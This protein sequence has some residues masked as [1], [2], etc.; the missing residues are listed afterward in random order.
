[1]IALLLACLAPAAVL[2]QYTTRASVTTSGALT[3]TGNALGLDG[4]EDDNEPG[5]R[6]AIGTF[7][8]TDTS[9][10]DGSFPNGTTNDWRSNRSEATLRLPPGARVIRAELIWGGTFAGEDDDEDVSAFIDDPVLFTTPAG[11]SEV[12]PDPATAITEGEVESDGEC[13]EQCY[14]VRTADV[15]A[16]IAASG[17]GRFAIA[18]VPGTQGDN[19]NND[20]VAGWTLAVLYEDFRQP[21]RNLTLFLGLEPSGGNAAQVSGFCTPPIGLLAGRLA[22]SSIEGDAK[23]TG[24]KL[25][26]G[27]TP[28][29]DNSN[30]V[31]GRRNPLD[32]FFSGQIT[33]D[34]GEL[35]TTGTFGNRNHSPGDAEDGA[36]QGWD[37]TNVDASDQLRNNQQTA[38]AQGTTDGDRYRI[39]ALGL[40]IDVG[41]PRFFTETPKTADRVAAQVGDIITYT[42]QVDNTDGTADAENVVFFDPPPTGTSFV[43]GSFTVDG[44]VRPAAD[45]V[46]GVPLGT[47]ARGASVT[48]TM[49]VQVNSVP[50]GPGAS[51]RS[52]QAQWTFDFVSCA[53]QPSQSS[54]AETNVVTTAVPVADL[55]VT[56]AFTTSPAVAGAP[57]TYTL[58]VSNAGPSPSVATVADSAS[59]PALTAVTWTCTPQSAASI[60]GAASGTGPVASTATL[61]PGGGVVYTV[62]GT[63]PANTP[64]GTLNNTASVSPPTAV[65]DL[66]PANNTANAS[67]PIVT[68]ADVRLTKTGPPSAQRGTDV[69]YSLVVTNNGPSDAVNVLVTD[70]APAGLIVTNFT[71]QCITFPGCALAAGASQT[72]SVVMAIPPDYTG[73]DPI[74]N[75]ANVTAATT[76]PKPA[77]NTARVTTSLDAPVADLAITKTDGVTSVSAGQT[78]TYT[79]TVTNAGPA[80]APSARVVDTFDPAVFTGVTWTCAASGTSSCTATGS[81]TGNIDTLVTLNPGAANAVVFTAQATIVATATG[82]AENTATVATTAGEGDPN[83]TNNS[84][85]DSDT[86]NPL[87]DVSIVQ[88]GPAS[89]VAGSTVTY[90]VVV[91]NS[92]PSVALAIPVSDPV[93]NLAGTENLG[94]IAAFTAPPGTTCETRPFSTPSGV[95]QLQF[96]DIPALAPNATATFTVQVTIPPD[97]ALD[98]IR[99]AGFIDEAAFSQQD[100]DTDDYVSDVITQIVSEADLSVVKTGPASVV[101]GSTASFF[102]R[103]VNNGPS[104]ATDIVVEDPVPA[105]LT[106]V[107]LEGPCAAGFPC[108][109]PSLA[110]GEANGVTTR[111][112]LLIP[113]DYA[114]PPTFVNTAT[115]SS[116]A[117][118]PVPSNNS[119]SV[120][121]LV[122]SA[123]ADL[124]V[125]KTGPSSVAPGGTLEYV[126][127]MTN[128][129]PGIATDVITSDEIPGGTTLVSASISGVPS[130]CTIPDPGTSNLLSCVTPVL[131]V[132]EFVEARVTAQASQDLVIG[133][134]ILNE[135]GV[136]SAMPDLNTA[137]NFAIVQTRVAA[138]TE[139][140]LKIEK[141]DDVDPVLSG[142]NVTY[143]L[144]VTNL[145]PASA[146][147]VS[148]VDTLPAGLSFVSAATTVGT[149]A[150]TTCSLGT[151]APSATAT[152]TIVAAATTTG[153]FQNVATVTAAEVDPAPANNNTSEPTTVATSDQADLAIEK[154]GPDVLQPGDAS[155]YQI[156]VTNR[157]PGMALDVTVND[158][159]PPGLTFLAN[160]GACV[161]AFPCSVELL[162]P[163]Q[164]FMISTTFSVDAGVPTPSTITNTATVGS[165]VTDDPDLSNNTTTSPVTTTIFPAGSADLG[166]RKHDSPDPVVAGTQYSYVLVVGNRGPSVA[167]AVIVVDP[168]PPGVT[169]VSVRSTIGTCSGSTTITC[170]LGT[171]TQ[172]LGA[173]IEI[174]ATVPVDL[175]SPNPMVNTATV[176]S[177]GTP[178]PNPL[179]DSGS[180]PT[181]VVAR[182][183]VQITK[184][185]PA[186]VPPGGAAVYTV[187]VTNAGPST[188]TGVTLDD[189]TP[190]GL[191]PLSVTGACTALPCSLGSIPPA[192]QRVVT[193]TVA[194]PP[195]YSGPVPIVNTA[196]VQATTNDINPANNTATATTALGAPVSDVS[197]VKTGP[198]S[199]RTGQQITYSL[200]VG[201]AGPSIATAV[202]LQD[203]TPAGLTFLTATAPC[204]AGF[205]CALGNLAPGASLSISAT[206]QAPPS[207]GVPQPIVNTA[208]VA[209]APADPFPANNTASVATVLRP[210]RIGCDVDGDG[211]DE[212]VTG[213]GPGGGPH[214]IVFSMAGGVPATLASFFAYDP[215]FDG[216]VYVA[217]G[218]VDG[219]GLADVVTGAGRGGGPHVRVFRVPPG[220]GDV[221]EIAS[222]WAYDPAFGGGVRVA[223]GDV[224][225]DGR[226]DVVTGAGPGGG[227]HVR[228]F[229]VTGGVPTELVSFYAYAPGFP[230]G[231]T[232]ASADVTGDRVAEI[233]T[234]TIRDGGPLRVFQIDGPAAIRELTSFYPY[235]E[236]FPGETRV[237][238]ADIDGD[239]VADVITGAGRFGGP[240]V[241]AFSLAGGRTTELA[242]FYA[243]D[244]V[245]CDLGGSAALR[246]CEGL[247][248]AGADITGDGRAEIIAA[249]DQDAGPVRIFQV[250]PGGIVLYTSFFA[251]GPYWLGP[252]RVGAVLPERNWPAPDVAQP[253]TTFAEHILVRRFERPRSDTDADRLPPARA[254][255]PSA[256]VAGRSRSPPDRGHDI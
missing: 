245:F 150:S 247:F 40:Q 14:Y 24:D 99:M 141:A 130:T 26:F 84:A 39:M 123:H 234:G 54:A 201:N 102:V 25:L 200:T 124:S 49:Q 80:S 90:T 146:T 55:S 1:V 131:P 125:E 33:D 114:G 28:A 95:T 101:A 44:A 226:A 213:V 241:R 30:R 63:L 228:A 227:P 168:L 85:T 231:V 74:V 193:V 172:G 116:A 160:T 229:S 178:D 224:N 254:D 187:T 109:I 37:I 83:E 6:G 58:T 3:F 70:P 45:P 23:L 105:G 69:T 249:N 107:A 36:R 77:N 139:A 9:Q 251:Y 100:P 205:P 230:G 133:A 145:G 235:F 13:D 11:T 171:L 87:A 184:S 153:L 118:D 250:V 43:A 188:A 111:V 248:V 143:T 126:I 196:T 61:P 19:D 203:P 192:G 225:G 207:L 127:R 29:L 93:L 72:L 194:V 208:T 66:V 237:A 252:V 156:R 94:L 151:L 21:I 202:V 159:L 98:A 50:P 106:I 164:S 189:P 180:Q 197:I 161:T 75:V 48:V 166:V 149:C 4:E 232:V 15:T 198:A 46:A 163:D 218:D 71:G 240:H 20:P 167:P 62:T 177:T 132:G 79:I 97:F 42:I 31:S 52:N 113:A 32:N 181:T 244:P 185:G 219:D 60:C 89:V 5:T 135:A 128:L 2:A 112:D 154:V 10:Q 129:G 82:Q 242:S 222:F 34:R 215:G 211:L 136:T 68:Q 204:A 78:T 233:I 255:R 243:Y 158:V 59:V 176:T 220:G 65:P 115:V 41:A 88:T 64:A 209:A 76:D 86:I 91:A 186:S 35:D 120:S 199:V 190:A 108:T 73:T 173:E 38:F 214:V 236:F 212:I 16:L 182:A 210:S 253:A 104:T 8:T 117:T 170:Q 191:V 169:A 140:D 206:F 217:C 165:I 81:Q 239:G 121:T 195:G 137:N 103:V 148:L 183:D 223:A 56:K 174:V 179:N 22:V 134:L 96:C 122:V 119:S 147:N 221:A 53:G 7:I 256:L 51:I 152:V 92:G 47:I 157:G 57:V 162:A 27:P 155:I 17:P 144:L 142:A 18:R 12:S 175:P 110:T 138:A 67:V 238:A 246:T 216:G